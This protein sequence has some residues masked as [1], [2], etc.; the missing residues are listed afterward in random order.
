MMRAYHDKR[1]ECGRYWN[2][3]SPLNTGIDA[4]ARKRRRRTALVNLRKLTFCG[5]FAFRVTEP[6]TRA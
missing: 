3:E 4:W 1:K 5:Q 6:A 2:E